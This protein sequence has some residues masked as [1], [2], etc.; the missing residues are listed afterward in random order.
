LANE[1]GGVL[2]SDWGDG[3]EEGYIGVEGLGGA[4]RAA[5]EVGGDLAKNQNR[6]A[7]ARFR[8][9]KRGGCLIPIGGV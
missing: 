6:A 9:T 8:L 7:G 2:D 1:T 4:E 5:R 3:F